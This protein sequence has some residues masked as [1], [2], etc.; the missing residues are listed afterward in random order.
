MDN[1]LDLFDDSSKNNTYT[2]IKNNCPHFVKED[3]KKISITVAS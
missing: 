1:L 3:I 2:Y